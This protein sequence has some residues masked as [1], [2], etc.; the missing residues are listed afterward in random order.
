MHDYL[1]F[2]MRLFTL[3]MQRFAC[4]VKWFLK[5]FSTFYAQQKAE[6]KTKRKR[7]NLVVECLNVESGTKDVWKNRTEEQNPYIRRSMHKCLV[8][9]PLKL[10]QNVTLNKHSAYLMESDSIV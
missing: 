10:W 8:D 9:K 1:A 6:K 7:W 4:L 5:Q 3:F 2:E